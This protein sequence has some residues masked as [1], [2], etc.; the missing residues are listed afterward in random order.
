MLEVL[1]VAIYALSLTYLLIYSLGQLHLTFFYLRKPGSGKETPSTLEEYPFVTIQLP[2]YNERYV[3]ERL[4]DAVETFD[5][6]RERFEV[7]L[8]DDS[9]DQ[10]YEIAK[11]HLKTLPEDL[12]IHHIR[13]ADRKGFKA[14]ALQ[15]G[16]GRAKGEF[17]AIFDAD[18]IPQPQFLNDCLPHFQNPAVGLV[19]TRWDHLNKEYSFLTKCQ[20]FGLDAHFTVEQAG[21]NK[22]DCFISFNGTAGMWRRECIDDAGGWHAD[23]LTEDLDLSY[24]AQ[25]KRWQ[26]VFLEKVVSPAELPVTINAFKSQQYRWNK[27]AAETHRKV[28]RD[29]WSA[30]L[31]KTVKFHALL[32]L[33]KGVGFIA[34]FLLTLFSVPVL[35]VKYQSTDFDYVFQ[36][37]TITLS[38]I[39]ILIFFYYASLTKIIN[40]PFKRFVY[41]AVRFPL[42]MAVSLGISLHNSIAVI[43]GYIGRKTP[44]IRTPKFNVKDGDKGFKNNIYA[45]SS[46]NLINLFEALL[47]CYFAFGVFYGIYTN[48]YSFVPFHLLLAIGYGLIVGYSVYQ[49]VKMR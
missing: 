46:I 23:T 32:Q 49:Q 6:P 26:F 31:S 9:D 19:Q 37:L 20:A 47:T 35:W 11:E 38:C 7:Q 29:V 42:F 16:L 21:R 33:F 45:L 10:S 4:L 12:C 22:A 40:S 18:F 17:I 13:R 39:F 3:V 1:I 24:R 15:Y 25:L 34:S 8:L 14:G 44:F 2:V 30:P 48:D 28:W 27:G 41:F 5:Y 43:E 36:L